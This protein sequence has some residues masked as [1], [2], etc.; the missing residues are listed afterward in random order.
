MRKLLTAALLA[1]CAVLS[2][3]VTIPTPA[4]AEAGTLP[5]A[6]YVTDYY[7]P[8]TDWFPQLP[9]ST[10]CMNTLVPDLFWLKYDNAYTLAL[11]VRPIT[12]EQLE[13]CIE[14]GLIRN[15]KERLTFSPDIAKKDRR[16]RTIGNYGINVP[17]DDFIEF[18]FKM[19]AKTKA[20]NPVVRVSAAGVTTI[21]TD[22]NEDKETVCKDGFKAY[23][24]AIKP[25]KNARLNSVSFSF[26]D[27]EA[28][29][30]D[31]EYVI[32]DICF[33]RSAP[34]A[35]FVDL[36]Q[37]QWILKTAF[38]KEEI[39]AADGI[40]DVVGYVESKPA[41]LESI[42]LNMKNP[43]AKNPGKIEYVKEKIN[44]K[45]MDAIRITLT[46]TNGACYLKFPVEK[47]NGMDFNTMTFY[48]KIQLPDDGYDK[49][50]VYGNN[51]PNMYGTNAAELNRFFDTFSFGIYSATKD[52]CDWNQYGVSQGLSAYHWQRDAK[53][54]EGW[55]A[56]ALDYINSDYAG[57]KGTYMPEITHWCFFYDSRKIPEGKQVVVTIAAPKMTKG[58]MY[59][60]GDMKKFKD[61]LKV[62]ADRYFQKKEKTLLGEKF[63]DSS[64]Y[65][66]PPTENRLDAALPF[67]ENHVI[68]GEIISHRYG[69]EA[70]D[71]ALNYFR[72]FLQNK[73]G[74]TNPLP[75][76]RAPSKVDNVKIFLGSEHFMKVDKQQCQADLKALAGKP[77]CVIRTR[78]KNIYIYGGK[79][80]YA[81]EARG[82]VNGIY[83]LIENNTDEIVTFH[84]VNRWAA[85]P[86]AV[87]DF[88][89]DGNFSIVWGKDYINKPLI[90]YWSA[91]GH[92][93][94][95]DRN[96][97]VP[98][99]WANGEEK[100][101]GR[102]QH[103]TNHWWGYG[104]EDENGH[105]RIPNDRWGLGENGKRM[106]PGCYTGHPC[107][108]NVL[109]N[110]K[111]EYLKKAYARQFRKGDFIWRKQDVFG[112]WVEDTLKVCVCDKCLTPIRLANGSL[113]MP[114]ETEFRGT[115]FFANACA[116]I[117]AVN[118][119]ARRDIKIESIGYFWM[120]CIPLFE[121]SRN[122]QIRFCPY[123]RKNYYD[124]IFAPC[125]DIFWRDYY[126]WSQ[127]DIELGVYEYFLQI[128]TRPWTD[129]FQFDLPLEAEH[130]MTFASPEADTSMLMRVE[131]WTL[132]RHF[133]D[134]SKDPREL[135]RYFIRRVY[136]EAA[137]DVEKFYFTLHNFIHEEISAV[138]PMEFEDEQ[139]VGVVAS[140]M[141]SKNGS[142]TV[143]DELTG[144]LKDA[145]K[146]VKHPQSKF[147][148]DTLVKEWE[149]YCAKALKKAEKLAK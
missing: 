95:S 53:T 77:G 141:K 30:P 38:D 88:V 29:D 19:K 42:D 119:F 36:P 105:Y 7:S 31:E 39:K 25:R 14:V 142:G 18:S 24:I 17:A 13:K 134:S 15:Q 11:R 100:Y 138:Y 78:G 54:P 131:H 132:L 49:R 96:F 149:A 92:P 115:Q 9:I 120:S 130:G 89:K 106:V 58:L 143:L 122:Y 82:I 34:K 20:K 65:L 22:K 147:V 62:R 126:R 59:A 104:A 136:R 47:F 69:H 73:Y 55:R 26:P 110:A 16:H 4:S 146:S 84:K 51:V 76:L 72:T 103:T 2:A 74:T 86:V 137:P 41:E 12:K 5:P 117:H 21:V 140:V 48:T 114:N 98:D 67:V 94:Y 144:Y 46:K 99:N 148:L 81:G 75:I 112:L 116:M 87:F 127:L 113:V 66:E 80:N 91:A 133:W 90:Q 97:S 93:D 45:E 70:I 128:G 129:T 85:Y 23:K 1:A 123:I 101:A 33:K 44:G 139:Q 71:R 63:P 50:L 52:A 118:T 79:A 108:I 102:R 125:N 40:K 35:R 10:Y 64:K 83:T 121:I 27:V 60:G 61:Y 8:S 28:Y 68:T 145:Q 32:F 37:R 109:E 107:M 6:Q 135:R 124:P 43:E 56:V 57:N 3:K 111:L